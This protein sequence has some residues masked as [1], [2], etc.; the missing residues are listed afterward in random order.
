VL[1]GGNLHLAE[2]FLNQAR[3]LNPND[4]NVQTEYGYLLFR[5]AV[6]NP[7]GMLAAEQVNQARELLNANIASRGDKDPHSYHV[8]GSNMLDWIERGIASHSERKAELE[9]LMKI[10]DDGCL[11]HP[12]N[13]HLKILREKLQQ[14]YLLLATIK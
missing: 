2:N 7:A 6:Q 8:L 12:S 3:A 9:A 5:K 10:I 4:M 14:S 1:E 13:E 11:K